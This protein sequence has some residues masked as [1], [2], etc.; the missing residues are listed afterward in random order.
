MI[1][2]FIAKAI[3]WIIPAILFCSWVYNWKGSP[4][5]GESKP[6]KE[7]SKSQP[8]APATVTEEPLSDS[9]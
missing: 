4:T 9:E 3:P 2:T 7:S 8:S 1:G 5:G 6:K